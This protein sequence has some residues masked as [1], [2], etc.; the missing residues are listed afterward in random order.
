M[1][2]A[3]YLCALPRDLRVLAERGGL[4]QLRRLDLSGCLSLTGE[5]LALLVG[6]CPLLDH[7]ALFYCDNVCPDPFPATASGCRNLEC[8]MRYCCRFGN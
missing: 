2:L 7:A 6:T 4:P 5:G 8:G 3:L 1:K